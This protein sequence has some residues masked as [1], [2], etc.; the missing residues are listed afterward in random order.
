MW[1]D[2]L[3][4]S[5]VRRY[6]SRFSSTNSPWVRTGQQVRSIREAGSKS[7]RP[8]RSTLTRS[9]SCAPTRIKGPF[10]GVRRADL[11]GIGAN[12]RQGKP[13]TKVEEGAEP[14]CKT[15][16]PCPC[17]GQ[18][19]DLHGP[20]LK[21]NAAVVLSPTWGSAHHSTVNRRLKACVWHARTDASRPH[22]WFRALVRRLSTGVVG[23]LAGGSAGGMGS[24]RAR[25]HP[26]RA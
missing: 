8:R 4:A 12:A 13:K 22:A 16:N 18:S 19:R 11:G 10:F 17:P 14:S 21:R 3:A 24:H 25:A 15:V 6:S 7:A 1:R 23:H 20:T 26:A 9:W 5:P 2:L